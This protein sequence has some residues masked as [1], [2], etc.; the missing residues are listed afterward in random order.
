[1]GKRQKS[2]SGHIVDL[3][4]I[5]SEEEL[6]ELDEQFDPCEHDRKLRCDACLSREWDKGRKEAFENGFFWVIDE[7]RKRC[8]KLYADGKD[9]SAREL[10]DLANSLID[11]GEREKVIPLAQARSRK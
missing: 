4:S 1:M 6:E 11:L 7:I 10:R 3:Q 5:F 8:G 2:D 9:G